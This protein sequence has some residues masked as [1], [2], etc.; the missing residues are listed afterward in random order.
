VL[1]IGN[2]NTCFFKKNPY[3]FDADKTPDIKAVRAF[4]FII[5][6]RLCRKLIR[7]ERRTVWSTM[8][9]SAARAQAR[10]EKRL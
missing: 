2:L 6:G 7:S 4:L 1:Q 5:P 8:S 3:F 9:P 10:T